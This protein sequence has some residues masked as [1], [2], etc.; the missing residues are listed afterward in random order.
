VPRNMA[1]RDARAYWT[2]PIF[3][4]GPRLAFSAA[5]FPEGRR[6]P[7]SGYRFIEVGEPPLL[8]QPARSGTTGFGLDVLGFILKDEL[9]APPDMVDTSFEVTERSWRAASHTR[10][11]PVWRAPGP[12]RVL[13]PHHFRGENATGVRK[14][15]SWCTRNGKILG[16]KAAHS[17]SCA[18]FWRC[19][20]R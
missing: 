15:L 13:R 3:P 19:A 12:P 5:D 14:M 16:E 4:H 7:V 17:G 1:G 9:I 6:T 20:V 8:H 2:A 18:S 11:R 10:S